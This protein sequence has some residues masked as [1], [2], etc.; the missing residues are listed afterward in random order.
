MKKQK[1]LEQVHLRASLARAGLLSSRSS[2]SCSQQRRARCFKEAPLQVSHQRQS[3]KA[4]LLL[5]SVAS[6]SSL[7]SFDRARRIST[8][9]L[10]E[11]IVEGQ[12]SVAGQ[13]QSKE[14]EGGRDAYPAVGVD[15][16]LG[17][18]NSG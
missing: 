18:V 5:L 2:T 7:F 12:L 1:L 10:L 8:P 15:L 13:I 6:L 3:G 16:L 17:R 11:R 4:L 14:G 9:L